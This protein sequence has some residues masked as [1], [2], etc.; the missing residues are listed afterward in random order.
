[1]AN[2]YFSFKQFTIYQDRCAMKVSTDACLFGAFIADW[3]S[4]QSKLPQS[5]L[6]I[7]TGTGLLSLMLAQKNPTAKFTAIELDELASV[8]AAENCANSPWH[9]QIKVLNQNVLQWNETENDLFDLIVCNPPFFKQHLISEEEQRAMARHDEHLTLEHLKNIAQKHLEE[10]GVIAFLLPFS[11]KEE[12]IELFE[13]E[14]KLLNLLESADNSKKPFNRVIC[15]FSKSEINH[16]PEK[17]QLKLHEVGGE[18]S[19]T[20]KGLI[21]DYYLQ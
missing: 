4:K 11:R 5:V 19:A 14:F 15:C 3:C 20:W 21:E 2:A 16:T 1:M 12:C 7:G 17:K 6:D 8:Q 13:K 18:R 10:Q 9:K